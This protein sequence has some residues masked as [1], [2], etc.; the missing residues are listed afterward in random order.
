MFFFSLSLFLLYKR[1]YR[2]NQQ[3]FLKEMLHI[4]TFIHILFFFFTSINHFKKI[5]IMEETDISFFFIFIFIFKPKSFLRHYIK[6][7]NLFSSSLPFQGYKHTHTHTHT[8]THLYTYIHTHTHAHHDILKFTSYYC[9]YI[10]V[11][12]VFFPLS[13]SLSLSLSLCIISF[14]IFL[15]I[16]LPQ[17]IY[18]YILLIQDQNLT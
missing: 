8:H 2:M 1:K 13:L 7:D 6:D 10:Q 16:L 5:V 12:K 9:L 17:S 4:F 15:V 18:I 14:L 3:Y 11:F